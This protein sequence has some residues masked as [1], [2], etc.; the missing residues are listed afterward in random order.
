MDS[1]EVIDKHH[2]LSP[3]E[4]QFEEMNDMIHQITLKEQAASIVS[5]GNSEQKSGTS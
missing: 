2:G 1:W 4:N 5:K 3:H